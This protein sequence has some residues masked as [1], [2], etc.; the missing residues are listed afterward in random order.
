MVIASG[1]VA[2]PKISKA[3]PA[4][5]VVPCEPAKVPSALSVVICTTPVVIDVVPA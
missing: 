2:A 3:A 4:T 1:I 5:T